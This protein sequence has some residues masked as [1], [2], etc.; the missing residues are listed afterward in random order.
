MP[1]S[2]DPQPGRLASLLSGGN[3]MAGIRSKSWAAPVSEVLSVTASIAE[4]A[5]AAGLPFAGLAGIALRLGSGALKPDI[6]QFIAEECG[7][8]GAGLETV[9]QELGLLR[10]T[11]SSGFE[12][13]AD[14][15]YKEGL[16]SI[17]AA[18]DTFL[19]L[20]SSGGAVDQLAEKMEE[21]RSH[22]FEL[23]KEAR[24][25]LVLIY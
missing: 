16:L 1:T 6:Q 11:V 14:C 18:F 8:L 7:Q 20:G 21:F 10:E 9:Q 25:H 4:L 17:E 12:I 19:N 2:P 15:R 13:I 23:E 5:G 3:I 22:K 24:H